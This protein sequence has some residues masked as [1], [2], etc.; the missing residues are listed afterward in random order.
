MS[1]RKI[2]QNNVKV[3][4]PY[5]QG[6]ALTEWHY[7]DPD[8]QQDHI[9]WKNGESFK[10]GEYYFRQSG[11][12]G[13]FLK[14]VPETNT[15]SYGVSSSYS[16][17]FYTMY[18]NNYAIFSISGKT[19]NYITAD[20]PSNYR[21]RS[22]ALTASASNVWPV[23]DGLIYNNGKKFY[24]Y[25]FKSNSDTLI[26]THANSVS[27]RTSDTWLSYG[28]IFLDSTEKAIY[29]LSI[30]G[31]CLKVFD[32]GTAYGDNRLINN[33]AVCETDSNSLGGA[34]KAIIGTTRREWDG[35]LSREFTNFMYFMT[36]I[37]LDGGGWSADHCWS[38][39]SDSVMAKAG[40]A[41]DLSYSQMGL[42]YFRTGNP[43]EKSKGFVRVYGA[44]KN[45]P[46]VSPVYIHD[47]TLFAAVTTEDHDVWHQSTDIKPIN[48]ADADIDTA[49]VTQYQASASSNYFNIG[50]GWTY[51]NA[52]ATG[53]SNPM[54]RR[55]PT[56]EQFES[57]NAEYYNYSNYMAFFDPWF[58]GTE[59]N[60]A[61]QNGYIG[62]VVWNEN[63]DEE[64]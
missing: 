15:I 26:Y 53:S 20:D 7:I 52:E 8:T 41:G 46:G 57:V 32:Y 4:Q 27:K 22:N 62:L 30:N 47:C 60:I 61:F 55:N 49:R 23:K 35:T 42:R 31:N 64:D 21:T 25:R 17:V 14:L 33:I 37:S 59:D 19:I 16:T 40:R 56:T 10:A 13:K 51:L 11:T 58:R 28:C 63:I 39:T 45:Q 1:I 36:D 9:V 2:Y 48:T 12:S 3:E 44:A 38:D 5:Y 29:S 34:E 6:V 43:T 50:P 54:I 24:H 18:W